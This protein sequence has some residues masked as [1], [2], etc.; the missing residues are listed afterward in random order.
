M[1]PFMLRNWPRAILHL[2]GDAF[3]AA[4]EQAINPSLRGHPVITGAERGIIT[5][6]SYEAKARGIQRGMRLGDATALCPELILLRSNYPAY[7]Q[8]SQHLFA[9]MRRFTPDV[10]EYSIDEGFADLTGLRKLYPGDGYQGIAKQMQETI[11]RELHI[12]VS[13]GLSVTKT[14]A[15]LASNA[16]KPHGFLVIPGS[17]IHEILA[18]TPIHKVWGIGPNT[19][20][21][22][23]KLGYPTAL[24]FAT[25]P[26]YR[27]ETACGKLGVERWLELRGEMV[28]PLTT[29][30]KT[31]CQS[32]TRSRTFTPSTQAR[33]LFAELLHNLEDA[34]AKARRYRLATPELTLWLKRQNFTIQHATIRLTRGTDSPLECASL[35]RKSFVDLFQPG[36][37][38]RT[39]G[40]TLHTLTPAQSVQ[41]SLFENLERMQ[42]VTTVTRT[43][44][45]LN[46]TYGRH[47]IQ[48]AEATHRH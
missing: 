23:R 6:A 33:F 41:P 14:L 22:L 31:S 47:T 29:A 36:T 20:A 26:R 18:D 7:Q 11:E 40:I 10:E 21:L 38:Y 43:M 27:I 12:T 3:F 30:A 13:A 2:D 17:A 39:T 5:A 16:R 45:Q 9:I 8:Y 42:K 4:V 28:Y 35:V 44:D 46:T 37:R 24:A 1:Q 48:L 19:A 34:L 25:A 15:K 32:I